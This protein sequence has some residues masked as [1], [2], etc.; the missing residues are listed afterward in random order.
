[1]FTRYRP[2]R[3]GPQYRRIKCADPKAA[4]EARK[5]GIGEHDRSSGMFWEFFTPETIRG[6]GKYV[7]EFWSFGNNTLVE[8]YE[9]RDAPP[10]LV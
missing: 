7:I 6:N 2:R 8:V 4:F 1:M 9:Q 3:S 5:A 10:C